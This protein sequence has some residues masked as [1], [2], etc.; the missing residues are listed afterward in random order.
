M[1]GLP[2]CALNIGITFIRHFYRSPGKKSRNKSIGKRCILLRK[3][4]GKEKN[5]YL[6][7]PLEKWWA[8]VQNYFL[9]EGRR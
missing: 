2:F 6:R 9:K 1:S 3:E 4:K 7:D 5:R 8:K